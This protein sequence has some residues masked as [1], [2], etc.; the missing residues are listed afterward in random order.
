MY[1][2]EYF[3]V[4]PKGLKEYGALNV[5][6][7]NDLPL[8]VDPFLL[9]TSKDADI[10]ELH[11]SL[12]DYVVFLKKR[13]KHR[14]SSGLIK[15]YYHFP[16]VSQNWLGFSETGNKG[17]GLGNKFATELRKNL[18]LIFKNFGRE[19]LT[20]ESH[21][22]KL[23]LFNEGIGRDMISD[24]TVNLIKGYLLRYTSEFT[25]S[26]IPQGYQIEMPVKKVRFDYE[27]ETWVPETFTLPCFDGDYVLLTPK[28]I[29]TKDNTWINRQDLYRDFPE[30]I[31]SM[32]NEQLRARINRYFTKL[33]PKH[34][35]QKTTLRAIRTTIAK[36][37][38]CI[39]QYIS[40]KEQNSRTAITKSSRR[41]QFV[42]AMH[43]DQIGT[44]KE[45]LSKH[46]E[47]F[48]IRP[49]SYSEAM[50]RLLHLKQVIEH[51]DGYKSFY[52][53][54]KRVKSERD[55][56]LA[57][58][59]VWYNTG[60]D[61]NAEPNNG[62]GPVDFKISRGNRDKTLVEFKLAKN[63]HLKKNLKHQIGIY[64][65][66]NQTDKAITVIIF[67][68]K[69]EQ[70]RMESILSELKIEK[71]PNLVVIDARKDNKKSASTV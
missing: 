34:P 50:S 31:E 14:L 57:F 68:S 70:V 56:Q 51:N 47:Y 44:L 36:Y 25:K 55:I 45:A 12:L 9:Y 69:E 6:L 19:R 33:L 65:K 24:F 23:C 32:D 41:V 30:V 48:D 54:G 13:S 5:S 7:I 21:L 22:E 61:V 1:F 29:L 53:K 37:P 67:F 49:D 66:A 20:L 11:K 58:K 27:T 43:I 38:I 26:H 4:D 18:P 15:Q 10:R 62:R 8:F 71:A 60:F 46:T 40:S 16:E 17:R 42:E 39:D 35:T 63:S 2:A 3:Q 59:L 52:F 64:K 28:S